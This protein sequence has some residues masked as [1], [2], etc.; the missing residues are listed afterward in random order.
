MRHHLPPWLKATVFLGLPL[1]LILAW[2]SGSLYS[3][4]GPGSAAAASDGPAVPVRVATL[5]QAAGGGALARPGTVVADARAVVASRLMATITAIHVQEGDVVRA[6]QPLVALDARDLDARVAA[7]QAGT[8]QA[9]AGVASARQ[10]LAVARS[11]EDR[12]RAQ[13]DAA[14]ET[15]R[16]ILALS[17][18][19]GATAQALTEAD[20]ALRM[21]RAS[22]EQARRQVGAAQAQLGQ[23]EAGVGQGRAAAR[24]A[25]ADR[26]YARLAAPFAGT[27]VKRWLDPGALAA[28][29]QA[30]LAL[31]R[32]PFR[33]DVSVEGG[34]AATLAPGAAVPVTLDSPPRTVTG[35]VARVVPAVDPGSRTA[36]VKVALPPVAGLRAGSFGRAAF[37]GG[38]APRVTLPAAALVRWYNLTSAFVVGPE[39]RAELRLVR[40]GE[41]DGAGHE[42]LDGL[43]AGD[44]VVV[45]P[46]EALRDGMKVEVL[47]GTGAEAKAEVVR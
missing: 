24:L 31:E 35:R 30:I 34:L 23:A 3:R 28:P 10:A 41:A 20:G 43:A 39:G 45:G 7:A 16:R 2:G 47:A 14:S 18:Q 27:V 32:G 40:L 25:A 26:S 4:V 22:H 13:L 5:D 46:P 29:G 8:A 1:A 11:G 9:V 6:G 42:V 38:Q 37:R 12:A 36:L 21:A 33:L 44:R 17:T 15:H 19:D